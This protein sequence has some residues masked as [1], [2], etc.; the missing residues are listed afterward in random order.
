VFEQIESQGMLA[1]AARIE[2][3]LKSGLIA[4]QEK[5]PIIGDVRGIGAMVAV[6]LVEPGTKKPNAAAVTAITAFAAQR[7]VLALSAGT[8]G[9]VLRFLPSL[10]ISDDLL[11]DA[12][13]VLDDAFAAL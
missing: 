9:N 1:Q 10:A 11:A 4:L 12:L 13:G 6:E 7:G 5:Y 3:V 2:R 8:Y